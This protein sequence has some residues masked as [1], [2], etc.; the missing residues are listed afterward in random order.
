MAL[1]ADAMSVVRALARTAPFTVR[2]DY[3]PRIEIAHFQS[4][5]VRVGWECESGIC[6]GYDES[7]PDHDVADEG[8]DYRG[9]AKW[10]RVERDTVTHRI[11]SATIECGHCG[12]ITNLMTGNVEPYV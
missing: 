7:E 4:L 5:D 11:T 12:L 3:G 2:P 10:A 6:N 1:N 9:W 8:E